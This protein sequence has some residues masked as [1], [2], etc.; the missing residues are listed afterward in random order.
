MTDFMFNLSGPEDLLGDFCASE[1]AVTKPC[2]L[3]SNHQRFVGC[4]KDEVYMKE[5]LPGLVEAYVLQ[6]LSFDS[7]LT[8]NEK[9]FNAAK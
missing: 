2:L 1:M 6:Q 3:F 9:I 4:Q 7:D 5:A 8:A